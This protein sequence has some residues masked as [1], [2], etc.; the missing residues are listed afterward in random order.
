MLDAA[1]CGG[2]RKADYAVLLQGDALHFH[3][4]QAGGRR[5]GEI[6]AG[7]PISVLR[8]DRLH[9]RQKAALRRPLLKDVVGGLGIH[10]DQEASLLHRNQV[11]RRLACRIGRLFQIDHGP[12]HQQFPAA[13]RVFD[14]TDLQAVCGLHVGDEPVGPPEKMPLHYLMILQVIASY[15]KKKATSKDVAFRCWRYLSSRAVASQV[16]SAGTSLTAVF[17]MGTGGPSP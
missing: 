4:M 11:I 6:Q 13:S 9:I 5:Q 8:L 15:A 12:R 16:L 10:I 1:L 17:G 2:V 14:M 7:V 3:Q